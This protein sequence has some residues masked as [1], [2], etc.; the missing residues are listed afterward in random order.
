MAQ[1]KKTALYDDERSNK[2]CRAGSRSEKWCDQS[3]DRG[4]GTVAEYRSVLLSERERELTPRKS[5]EVGRKQD[6]NIG[7]KSDNSTPIKAAMQL[8]TSSPG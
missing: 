4:G 7:S 1:Q 3:H 6:H 5:V 2:Q 8:Q